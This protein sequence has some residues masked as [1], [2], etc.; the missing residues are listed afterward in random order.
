MVAALARGGEPLILRL[1]TAPRPGAHPLVGGR[2]PSPGSALP[3]LVWLHLSL[4]TVA[5]IIGKNR[6]EFNQLDSKDLLA[7]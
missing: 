4:R 5:D 3:S 6:K 2:K 1:E 7:T